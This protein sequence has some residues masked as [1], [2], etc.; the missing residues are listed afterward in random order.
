MPFLHSEHSLILLKTIRMM[1]NTYKLWNETFF[2]FG[3][4]LLRGLS[5]SWAHRLMD[6]IQSKSLR[7][8]D[9]QTHVD[10]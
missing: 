5:Q 3:A 10:S 2:L 7:A 4:T 8:L 1:A 9:L 6:L